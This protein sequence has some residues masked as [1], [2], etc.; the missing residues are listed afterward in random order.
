MA[1]GPAPNQDAA[2]KARFEALA[3]D[4]RNA[5]VQVIVTFTERWRMPAEILFTDEKGLEFRLRYQRKGSAYGI[6]VLRGEEE[7]DL[8]SVN[9][10]LRIHIVGLLDDLW[11]ACAASEVSVHEDIK[12]AT[13]KAIQWVES[14]EQR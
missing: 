6:F 12:A 10:R 8:L 9:Q 1:L 11:E 7:T 14:K 13:E 4:F 5:L 3:A 2:T